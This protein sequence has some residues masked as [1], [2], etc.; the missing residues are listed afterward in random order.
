[1]QSHNFLPVSFLLLLRMP[2]VNEPKYKE[3]LL[4]LTV[5]ISGYNQL[6]VTIRAYAL[7]QE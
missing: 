2:E 6:A 1:M 5:E 3:G 7:W 4:R